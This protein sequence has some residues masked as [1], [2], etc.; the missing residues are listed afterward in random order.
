MLRRELVNRQII[1]KVKEFE[2]LKKQVIKY[3]IIV[4]LNIWNPSDLLIIPKYSSIWASNPTVTN[5]TWT[6]KYTNEK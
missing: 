1:P 4:K 5:N 6:W 3:N 2:T